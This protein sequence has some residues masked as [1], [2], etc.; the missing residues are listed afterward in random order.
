MRLVV[1]LRATIVASARAEADS[2]YG[3]AAPPEGGEHVEAG[4]VETVLGEHPAELAIEHA[5][6]PRDRAR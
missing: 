4:P 5:R 1:E 3:R 6:R 2:R